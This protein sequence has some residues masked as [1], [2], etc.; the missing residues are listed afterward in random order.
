MESAEKD[1]VTQLRWDR[2]NLTQYKELTGAYL[3]TVYAVLAET[4]FEND[5][6]AL[7]RTNIVNDIYM[8]KL[9][10]YY[11][12]VQILLYQQSRKIFLSSAGM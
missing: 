7:D 8:T 6:F 10:I 9:Y 12:I 1:D 3:Q 11:C 2:A 4:E 5:S